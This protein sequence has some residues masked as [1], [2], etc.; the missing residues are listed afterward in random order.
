MGRLVATGSARVP[1][2]FQLAT[3]WARVQGDEWTIGVLPPLVPGKDS[4]ACDF[5]ESDG[6][7]VIGHAR[8]DLDRMRAVIWSKD[9]PIW[10]LTVLPNLP[11]GV[12]SA[13][14]DA[15]VVPMPMIAGWSETPDGD[16][17]AV[18]WVLDDGLWRLLDLG[19]PDGFRSSQ[20]IA[21]AWPDDWEM[22]WLTGFADSGAGTAE[23]M[24]WLGM[25]PDAEAINLN[26]LVEDE[27]II[28][29]ATSI[30]R[31]GRIAAWGVQPG[32]E[33]EPRAFVLTVSNSSYCPG[34]LDGDGD[35]DLSDLAQLLAHYGETTGVTP[36]DGDIDGDGD[37]DLS[38]LAG[39]LAHY[40]EDCP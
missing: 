18:S 40:G 38:D 20:A 36:E 17:H 26:E 39:L 15:T 9:G 29:R 14:L 21:G 5:I 13:A 7:I 22:P 2:G 11:G 3:S 4:I 31:S 1:G 19:V 28:R 35:I 6:P 16:R 10:Q 33:D 12:Q 8:D 25:G 27:W 23:A 24:L 37:V 32:A 30:S 34:D